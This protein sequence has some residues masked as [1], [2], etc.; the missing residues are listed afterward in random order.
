MKDVGTTTKSMDGQPMQRMSE[1][2]LRFVN[3]GRSFHYR[4]IDKIKSAKIFAIPTL[5]IYRGFPCDYIGT[6]VVLS[7]ELRISAVKGWVL[8]VLVAVVFPLF[9]RCYSC[10]L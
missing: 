7:P 5:S 4:A 9:V 1:C 6:D 8:H 2:R 3:C 10:I